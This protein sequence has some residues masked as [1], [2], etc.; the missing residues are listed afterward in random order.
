MLYP[1]AA[2]AIRSQKE[3]QMAG[4]ITGEGSLSECHLAQIRTGAYRFYI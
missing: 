2:M 4:P 3:N 1:Q